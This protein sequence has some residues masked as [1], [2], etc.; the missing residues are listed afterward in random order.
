MT[1]EKLVETLTS[2]LDDHW[3]VEAA[4]TTPDGNIALCVKESNSESMQFFLLTI[5]EASLTP[6]SAGRPG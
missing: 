3:P 4:V 6:L 2:E 1:R 5:E